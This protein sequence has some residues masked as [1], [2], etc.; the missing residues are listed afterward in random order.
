MKNYDDDTMCILIPDYLK[1]EKPAPQFYAHS[2]RPW[3]SVAIS[4]GDDDIA[5]ELNRKHL[6]QGPFMGGDKEKISV[7]F[8]GLINVQ[9]EGWEQISQLEDIDTSRVF[10]GWIRIIKIRDNFNV[11]ISIEGDGALESNREMWSAIMDSFHLK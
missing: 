5:Y 1:V 4:I 11:Y 9:G 10:S 8:N 2:K 3:L 7:T 6:E